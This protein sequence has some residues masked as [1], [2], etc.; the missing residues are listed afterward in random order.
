MKTEV[1]FKYFGVT[2]TFHFESDSTLRKGRMAAHLYT[3]THVSIIIVETKLSK[4]SW[5]EMWYWL[6]RGVQ[7]KK[8]G[9]R[10]FS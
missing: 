7:G 8:V 10:Q 5:Q 3:V 1:T 9:E 2:F 4:K 6:G